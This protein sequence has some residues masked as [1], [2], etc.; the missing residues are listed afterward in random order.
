MDYYI[1]QF[2]IW[3]MRL[4]KEGYG[5]ITTIRNLEVD[6]FFNLIHYENYLAEYSEAFRLLNT[7]KK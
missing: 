7:Q 5:D 2:D 4:S 3:I 6:K 1:S